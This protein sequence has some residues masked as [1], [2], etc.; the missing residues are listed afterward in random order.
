MK[1]A[2]AYRGVV[3]CERRAL[4]DKTCRVSRPMGIAEVEEQNVRQPYT[5]Q[6]GQYT[7]KLYLVYVFLVEVVTPLTCF[8]TFA[9][10][11]CV[12]VY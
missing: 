9:L 7:S 10:R 6:Y 1:C 5:G 4:A 8:S 3:R 2:E 11:S 12:P